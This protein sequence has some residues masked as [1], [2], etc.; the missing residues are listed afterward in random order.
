MYL[1]LGHWIS[2]GYGLTQTIISIH[3]LLF[4]FVVVHHHIFERGTVGVVQELGQG[5]LDEHDSPQWYD[6]VHFE[7]KLSWLCFGLSQKASYQW[8]QH[9]EARLLFSSSFGVFEQS[10]PFLR[11]FSHFLT[12][13]SR[14]T[15]TLFD[16]WGFYWHG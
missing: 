16:I 14:L 5:L 6:I 4:M 2:T 1:S 10:T 11:Y 7:H 9:L 15:N 13:A 12:I 3:R 8:S